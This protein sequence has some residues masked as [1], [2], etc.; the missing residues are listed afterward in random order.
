MSKLLLLSSYFY[1][2]VLAAVVVAICI[3]YKAIVVFAVY[4]L[5]QLGLPRFEPGLCDEIVPIEDFLRRD[6][7]TG[8]QASIAHNTEPPSTTKPAQQPTTTN[9][10]SKP[11]ID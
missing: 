6:R 10:A 11:T 8:K 5:L 1:N 4:D 7:G 3:T 2:L 9:R